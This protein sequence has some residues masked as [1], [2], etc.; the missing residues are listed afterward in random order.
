MQPTV[1]F[2]IK[3]CP[4]DLVKSCVP[5]NRPDFRRFSDALD[6]F[7]RSV[8]K[9]S[10]L[11]IWGTPAPTHPMPWEE[12]QRELFKAA[13][14]QIPSALGAS[15][16]RTILYMF[17]LSRIADRQGFDDDFW[18]SLQEAADECTIKGKR[19]GTSC[20][21]NSDTDHV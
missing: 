16:H 3:P 18:L 21:T 20:S 19:D 7:S 5:E 12:K 8:G 2:A 14:S 15:M 1:P 10:W 6:K 4:T 9:K 11:E 13:V 17:E